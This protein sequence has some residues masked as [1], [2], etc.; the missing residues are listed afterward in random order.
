VSVTVSDVGKEKEKTHLQVD[1]VNRLDRLPNHIIR[2]FLQVSDLNRE[3]SPFKPN[4]NRLIQYRFLLLLLV[5]STLFR[6]WR[7]VAV[8]VVGRVDTGGGVRGGG[9]DGVKEVDKGL[10]FDG[11]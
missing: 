10:G 3:R 9:D 8:E 11:R 5:P 1:V 2:R 4:H 7:L 6:W